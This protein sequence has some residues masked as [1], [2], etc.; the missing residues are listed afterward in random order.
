[1]RTI[2]KISVGLLALMLAFVMSL[3][4]V[5]AQG[6]GSIRGEVVDE[7]GGLIVGATITVSDASGAEKAAARTNNEGSFV[8]NGLAPGRY[9]VTAIAPGFAHY[10][11]AQVDV[12]QG[13]AT[14]LDIKLNVTIEDAQVTV[15]QQ[16]PVDTAPE[17]NASALV[18]S[19]NDL[20]ALPDD[21]DE[22]AAALQALA[23]PSAGPNGGQFYI[24]GFTG[25]RMPPK[26][27]IREIRI[28]QNPFSAEYDRLGFGRVE[29]FTKPG[30]DRLRGTATLNFNNQSL[31]SRNPFANVRAPHR[32][33]TYSG[34]LS[35]PVVAK[36]A[37][38]FLDFERRDINDN[39]VVNAIIL[40]QNLNPVPF[41][42]VVIV[43]QRRTTFSPR[44]DYQLNASNTL[45]GRYS[46]TRS[47]L[48]N[49]GIGGFSLPSRAVNTKNTEHSV[50]LTE[51]AVLTPHLLNETRFQF[52]RS[53]N[54]TTGDNSQ[55]TL[56][57]RD[58]FIGGGSSAGL[59]SSTQSNWELQ[60]T[61]SWVWGRHSIKAGGR[62]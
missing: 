32:Q 34:N 23:G 50:Q 17:N 38:F 21:P 9:T 15:A 45:V 29:I 22:L 18:L 28:N 25:G 36:K 31:N 27:S 37:S 30:T 42:D 40:D 47:T 60:N 44:I 52:T 20:E 53:T 1:M 13:R 4:P 54:R 14:R 49:G 48:E 57:V 16:A 55:P 62:L 39:G 46:F 51:T 5:L 43:P 8:I 61:T 58:A 59:A 24:D 3:L 10:E 35:G 11:N 56:I 12:T 7:F 26:N 19:G 6:A 41:N 2:K 33:L